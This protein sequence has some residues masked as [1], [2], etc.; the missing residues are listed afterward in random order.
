MTDATYT[1]TFTTYPDGEL[2]QCTRHVPL[3]DLLHKYNQSVQWM[4]NRK[5]GSTFSVHGPGLMRSAPDPRTRRYIV[6]NLAPASKRCL[7]LVWLS[8]DGSGEYDM[9]KVYRSTETWAEFADQVD[10]YSLDPVDPD[11]HAEAFKWAKEIGWRDWGVWFQGRPAL[12]FAAD[13]R[14][15]AEAFEEMPKTAPHLDGGKLQQAPVKY[16]VTQVSLPYPMIR[17]CRKRATIQRLRSRYPT[18]G[19]DL[20][21]IPEEI[22]YQRYGERQRSS[23]PELAY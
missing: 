12:V 21:Y 11:K 10:V 15:I 8:L 23:R 1:F 4:E 20:A 14:P 3:E 16:S 19:E 5:D 7:G 22:L 9:H 18:A 2:R 6:E 17:T 13:F